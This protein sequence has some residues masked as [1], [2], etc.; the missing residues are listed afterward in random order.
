MFA[1]LLLCAI[2]QS[3]D[4]DALPRWRDHIA[5]AAAESRWQQIGWRATVADG[6]Q[7]AAAAD[8][9]LLLWLMNGHPL[10]CT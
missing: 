8:R 7:E 2:P 9:P 6:L 5:P 4:Q 3:L 1:L 10:G